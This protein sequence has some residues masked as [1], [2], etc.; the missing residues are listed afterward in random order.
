MDKELLQL[1][2]TSLSDG[3]Q[4]I[5]H[6]IVASNVKDAFESARPSVVVRERDTSQATPRNTRPQ[7][8]FNKISGL[9][10]DTE[11]EHQFN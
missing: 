10:M 9:R 5:G 3:K 6:D 2:K 7:A 1:R 8:A 11:F 4:S